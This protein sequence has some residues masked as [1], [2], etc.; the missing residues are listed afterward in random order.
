M[1]RFFKVCCSLLLLVAVILGVSFA[2]YGGYLSFRKF[3]ELKAPKQITLNCDYGGQKI[4]LQEEL[5]QSVDDYYSTD[6]KKRGYTLSNHFESFA[7]SYPE[8]KTVK[9]LTQKI[10]NKGRQM[11]LSDDKT[12][13]L[14]TCFVQ[15]IPYD[16][17]KAKIVLSKKTG[18]KISGDTFSKSLGRFPYETL[19]D[20]T[21]ICT[22]KSYLEAA[23]LKE[24]GYGVSL[25]AFDTE[26]HMAVGVKTPA[27]Y[28][29]FDTQ[30]SYLETTNTGYKVGQI[31]VIDK[32]VGGAKK[33][34]LDKTSKASENS[35]GGDLIDE[36][37]DPNFSKPSEMFIVAD[38][39]DYMRVIEL[40]KTMNRIK[41][42]ITEINTENKEILAMKEEL[43]K[44]EGEV[45]AAKRETDSYEAK[46]K[47]SQDFY[48]QY[49]ASYY[50]TLQKVNNYNL[51]IRN[52]NAKIVK[53]NALID[54]YNK[55][56]KSD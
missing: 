21:G 47:Q 28:T 9:D 51:Q 22:D 17:A 14:A 37:P 23:I 46:V 11:G 41:A 13:D 39:K 54:E 50:R 26:R 16:E 30:Y 3:P 53:L 25:M 45:E 8:D 38:G 20:N 15:N 19:Y 43:K 48:S 2:L 55:L 56:L 35:L 34:E 40:A 32:N 33:A 7:Y 52:Y 27:G 31:P 6:P 5:Y 36:M 29:S 1:K 49:E 12:M 18:E 4:T 44:E 10:K 42:L 24:M